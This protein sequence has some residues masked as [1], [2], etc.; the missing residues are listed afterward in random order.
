MTTPNTRPS[1]AD[2]MFGSLLWGAS[3]VLLTLKLGGVIEI[4]WLYVAL[5]ILINLGYVALMLGAAIVSTMLANSPRSWLRR[6]H[7]RTPVQTN[8]SA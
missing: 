4:G 8:R 3:V 6:R 5:P 7:R 2:Q 1:L